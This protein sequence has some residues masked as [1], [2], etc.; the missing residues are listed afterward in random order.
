VPDTL[1]IVPKGTSTYLSRPRHP[2]HYHLQSFTA[3]SIIRFSGSRELQC[4]HSSVGSVVW[5]YNRYSLVQVERPL[6]REHFGFGLTCNNG[7]NV[8][9]EH[10]AHGQMLELQC[11]D[12]DIVNGGPYLWGLYT[13]YGHQV[14]C[15]LRLLTMDIRISTLAAKLLGKEQRASNWIFQSQFWS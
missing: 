1:Y 7:G 10:A 13:T 15:I 4:W 14:L 11:R 2:H 9:A 12:R 3:A 6:G 8:W 5:S